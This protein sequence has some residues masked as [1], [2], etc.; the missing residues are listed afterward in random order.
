MMPFLI[1]AFVWMIAVFIVMI[2]S[3]EGKT[4]YVTSSIAGVSICEWLL[5]FLEVAVFNYYG[6]VNNSLYA[7]CGIVL[8]CFINIAFMIIYL[9]LFRFNEI[10]RENR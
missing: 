3:H 9:K 5:T 6:F 10:I 8:N 7:A 2:A 1:L 4:W